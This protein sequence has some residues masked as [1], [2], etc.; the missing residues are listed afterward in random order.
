MSSEPSTSKA[1][2]PPAE[3][4]PTAANNTSAETAAAATATTTTSATGDYP[5]TPDKKPSVSSDAMIVSESKE[6]LDDDLQDAILA[7]LGQEA[8]TAS[9][10]TRNPNANANANPSSSN[11]AAETVSVER[12]EQLLLEA[13]VNRL[14]WIHRVP[15]P[16][17]KAESPDD[18]WVQEEGLAKFL[19]TCHAAALMP[20]MTK[21]LSHLYGIE[22]QRLTPEDVSSRLESLVRTTVL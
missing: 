21:V 1:D 13:R 10:A 22:D 7:S 12:K 14:Q 3:K 8:S 4:K 11:R 20:S 6:F 18:P 5:T 15:L 17:R 16:Y 19:T 2:N 9:R